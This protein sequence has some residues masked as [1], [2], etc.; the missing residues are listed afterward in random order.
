MHYD[1]V[2]KLIEVL[3]R[4]V[5]AGN[6]ALVISAGLL[7]ELCAEEFQ[8]LIAHELA[9]CRRGD[10]WPAT[11]AALPAAAL[12]ALAA[13]LRALLGFGSGRPQAGHDKASGHP[14]GEIAAWVLHALAGM[15]I[16]L[17]AAPGREYA[18]DQLAGKFCG[19]PLYLAGALRKLDAAAAAKNFSQIPQMCTHLLAVPVRVTAAKKPVFKTHPD[20]EERMVRLEK[21]AR[22]SGL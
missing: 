17:G 6:T 8:A 3:Q 16:R 12:G 18:A 7:K 11:Q 21:M 4:L 22:E 1:D 13:L 14:L 10:V 19:N 2:K 20:T 15:L 9:H 5:S